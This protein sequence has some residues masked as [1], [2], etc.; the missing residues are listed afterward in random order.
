MSTADK[1]CELYKLGEN[2]KLFVY[3]WVS[4][5]KTTLQETKKGEGKAKNGLVEFL[6]PE[7]IS[8]KI[9]SKNGLGNNKLVFHMF[10]CWSC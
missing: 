2:K 1:I 9:K 8:N 4:S 10:S 5:V 6:F 7:G 3:M